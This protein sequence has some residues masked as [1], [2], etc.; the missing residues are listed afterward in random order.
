MNLIGHYTIG[1]TVAT[2]TID[3]IPQD[4]RGL[5]AV[6]AFAGSG[7]AAGQNEIE[8]YAN[9]VLTANRLTGQGWRAG[10]STLSS[11][12]ST[13]YGPLIPN[14]NNY[15]N[16]IAYGAMVMGI[17]D[18][19]TP[20]NKQSWVYYTTPNDAANMSIGG[21]VRAIGTAVTAITSLIFDILTPTTS[22]I[23]AG[24]RISLYKLN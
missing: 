22:N 12:T 21:G 3:N 16:N 13:T 5:F 15:G 20:D 19:A 2:Y 17:G 4:G 24:S 9:S 14:I 23:S 8:V 6:I 1:T 11:Q 18:Y 10:S 7:T